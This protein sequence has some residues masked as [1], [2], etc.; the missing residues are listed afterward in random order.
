MRISKAMFDVITAVE[1]VSKKDLVPYAKIVQHLGRSPSKMP[2]CVRD[3]VDD[4]FVN[5]FERCRSQARRET[6]SHTESHHHE[7]IALTAMNQIQ[8]ARI[9]CG[10]GDFITATCKLHP[11]SQSVFP[12]ACDSIFVLS[13]RII[14]CILVDGAVKSD[15]YK[16]VFLPAAAR[17]KERKLPRLPDVS[18]I[19]VNGYDEVL[20]SF[21][22]YYDFWPDPEM[23]EEEIGI[24]CTWAKA[25]FG[26]AP[27][28]T[29]TPETEDKLGEFIRSS[30][31]KKTRALLT[32]LF[33]G[34]AKH[35]IRDAMKAIGYRPVSKNAKTAFLKLVQRTIKSLAMNNLNWTIKTS[36]SDI[37]LEQI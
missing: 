6:E 18:D 30:S 10:A 25:G 5:V 7:R 1:Q 15:W 17:F 22:A 20:K 21:R 36:V 19:V 34:G 31:G 16:Q 13:Y 27:A 4:L 29:S 24:E 14:K 9:A 35:S 23:I 8:R 26:A 2:D 12:S 32:Y 37:F 3:S 33:N 11:N 28:W